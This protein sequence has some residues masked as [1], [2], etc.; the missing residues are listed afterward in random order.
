ML[1]DITSYGR[2]CPKFRGPANPSSLTPLQANAAHHRQRHELTG[3]QRIAVHPIEGD[4][5]R[6]AQHDIAALAQAG[7][8]SID[9]GTGTQM[10]V[11]Y[12]PIHIPHTECSMGFHRTGG[13]QKLSVA[14]KS[15]RSD[16]G[17]NEL[18]GLSVHRAKARGR[19][20]KILS[21]HP[22]SEEPWK[23]REASRRRPARDRR[24]I[25][26]E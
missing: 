18:A 11:A 12:D 21:R 1:D 5:G 15:E 20:S 2:G 13:R 25:S 17:Q 19:R 22:I 8:G 7:I 10:Q 16:S 4:P 26:P 9:G 23:S 3:V 6:I 24:R 14:G